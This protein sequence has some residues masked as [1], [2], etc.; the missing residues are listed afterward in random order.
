[1]GFSVQEDLALRIQ[2]AEQNCEEARQNY[3]RTGSVKQI[4]AAN[5]RLG[6]LHHELYRVDAGIA[7]GF[8]DR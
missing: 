6:E 2:M 7:K 5:R 1:M 8:D 3:R 4:N